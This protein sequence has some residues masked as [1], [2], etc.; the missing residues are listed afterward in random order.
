MSGMDIFLFLP[1]IVQVIFD[2]LI[3]PPS[4]HD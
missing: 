1:I 3:H 2:S 4:L